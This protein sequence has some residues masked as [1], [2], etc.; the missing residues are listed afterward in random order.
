MERDGEV[1]PPFTPDERSWAQ[2]VAEAYYFSQYLTELAVRALDRRSPE[3]K[4]LLWGIHKVLD[5]PQ[6]RN[7]THA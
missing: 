4:A 7:G 5:H 1:A 6:A 2:A 3:H